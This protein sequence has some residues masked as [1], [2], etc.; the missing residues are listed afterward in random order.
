MGLLSR[1]VPFESFFDSMWAPLH[2]EMRDH[3]LTPRV[4]VVENDN[5]YLIDVDMPG[6][7]KE[8]ISITL[9][10]GMLTIEAE[11]KTE[12]EEKKD[13]HVVRKERYY[14]KIMRSFEIGKDV[15]ESDID[16]RFEDGVLKLVAPKTEATAPATK[17]IEIH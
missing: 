3:L 10:N 9:N 15:Q 8:D 13:G 7:K 11:T 6:V 12:D 2:E 4:D 5:K 1:H 16:A 14:G 17:R